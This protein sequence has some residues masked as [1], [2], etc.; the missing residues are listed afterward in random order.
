[1]TGTKVGTCNIKSVIRFM[2]PRRALRLYKSSFSLRR[3]RKTIG[4]SPNSFSFLS[5]PTWVYC[6]NFGTEFFQLL[7][8]LIVKFH[9]QSFVEFFEI[10]V[11]R[12]FSVNYASFIY[13]LIHSDFHRIEFRSYENC[14]LL[15]YHEFIVKFIVKFLQST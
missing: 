9:F 5:P 7:I 8:I 10:I 13:Q 6:A 4:I 3:L 14:F 1:M 2:K 12:S 11:A 15:K